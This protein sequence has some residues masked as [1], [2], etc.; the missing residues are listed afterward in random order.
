M[1][2]LF[3]C[4]LLVCPF[5]AQAQEA[6]RAADRAAIDACLQKETDAPERCIGVVYHPCTER[7]PSDADQFP[8]G[9]TP[10]QEQCAA[11]ERAVWQEKVDASLVALRAGPLG[12]T[13]AQPYNRPAATPLARPEPGTAI[14]D[15]MQRAWTLS[16]AK[17]CDTE[18][19]R[20]EGGTFAR[21]VYATCLYAMT[22]RHALWLKA[23]QND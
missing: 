15:D 4:L 23:L 3:I 17:M 7:P 14:L 21:T 20:Y 5:V 1:R 13:I 12:Q 18:A 10:G 6:P 9:S 8:P 19:L 22:A 2:A 11:R 16:R